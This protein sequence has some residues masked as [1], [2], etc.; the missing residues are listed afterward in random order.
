VRAVGVWMLNRAVVEDIASTAR[1]ATT[2]LYLFNPYLIP[3][4][5][6]VHRRPDTG[7]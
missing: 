6:L 4:V 5:V 3:Y 7:R 2:G 1:A